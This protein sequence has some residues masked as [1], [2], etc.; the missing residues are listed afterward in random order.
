MNQTSRNNCT[1]SHRVR[2]PALLAC[3]A[4]WSSF[5]TSQ[6]VGTT[7]FIEPG[8]PK[9]G[10]PERTLAGSWRRRPVGLRLLFSTRGFLQSTPDPLSGI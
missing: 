5:E 7:V 6:V 4:L 3:L 1:R 10:L 9:E 2:W 8:G